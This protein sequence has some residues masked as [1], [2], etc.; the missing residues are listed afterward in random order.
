M[1]PFSRSTQQSR[2]FQATWSMVKASFTY[3]FLD[4]GLH[5]VPVSSCGHTL[6]KKSI[7]AVERESKLT[8]S[9]ETNSH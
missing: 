5:V 6:K 4:I 2:N 1:T 3:C 7:L 9:S 8:H